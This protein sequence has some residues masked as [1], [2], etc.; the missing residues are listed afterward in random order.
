MNMEM[1][2]FAVYAGQGRLVISMSMIW[3]ISGKRANRLS[4]LGGCL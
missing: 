2:F 1:Y 4:Y 3:L